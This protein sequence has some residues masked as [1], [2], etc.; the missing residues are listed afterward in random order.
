MKVRASRTYSASANNY[1]IS[2]EYDCTVIP[3]KGM[4]FIDP[5]LTESGVIQPVEIIEVTIE[6]ESNSCHVLLTGDPHDHEKEEL[7]KKFKTMKSHGWEY[8]EG[9]L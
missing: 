6:P 3:V 7:K 4:C 8:I 1:F 5:G 9:L 2:K